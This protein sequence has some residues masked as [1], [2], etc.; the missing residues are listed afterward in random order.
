MLGSER[1]QGDLADVFA[2]QAELARK[3]AGSVAPFVRSIE[4]RRARITSFEQ[5]D[6]YAITLRGIDLM[7]R[8][9]HEDFLHARSAF[10]NAIE[11]DPISP[12]PHA[13]LPEWD[14]V[15]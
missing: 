2:M 4:L 14:I 1:F 8:H 11:R 6:A 9:T 7:H 10:E 5:L 13:W 12:A 3:V 15:C